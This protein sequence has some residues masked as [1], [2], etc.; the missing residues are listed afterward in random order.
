[1]APSNE[2]VAADDKEF[3]SLEAKVPPI[4]NP[5]VLG[6]T[7]FDVVAATKKATACAK[8]D[9]RRKRAEIDKSKRKG[10]GKGKKKDATRSG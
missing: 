6:D 8:P 2:F 7:S 4:S 10:K 3:Y 9:K 5:D 1:M